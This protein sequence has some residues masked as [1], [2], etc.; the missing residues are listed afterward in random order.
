[1]QTSTLARR[2]LAVVLVLAGIA[3]VFTGLHAIYPPVAFVALG[4]VAIA[5]GMFGIDD[6]TAS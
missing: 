6:G 2:A 1:M 5:A 3:L 4:A